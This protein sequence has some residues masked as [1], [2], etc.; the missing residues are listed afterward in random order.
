MSINKFNKSNWFFPL[1]IFCVCFF[2][3]AYQVT[4]MGFYWDDW[5]V[6]YLSKLTSSSAFWSYFAFDRPFSA[7]THL[8]AFPILGTHPL[9][10]QLFTILLRWLSVLGFWWT[11][12]E[13]WPSKNTEVGWMALLMAVYPGFLQQSISVAYSQHF[14]CYALFYLLFGVNGL[15]NSSSKE[16]PAFDYPLGPPLPPSR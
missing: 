2:T 1:F 6:I 12:R 4:R 7:W 11:F 15:G 8:L 13:V 16:S 14:M 3:Y 9:N 5:P 10:W